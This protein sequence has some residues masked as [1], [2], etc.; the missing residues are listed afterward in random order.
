M[1]VGTLIYTLRFYFFCCL[2]KK[3]YIGVLASH[4]SAVNSFIHIASIWQQILMLLSLGFLSIAIELAEAFSIIYC[5]V[6]NRIR[7]TNCAKQC[8][9]G[10]HY[11]NNAMLIDWNEKLIEIVLLPIIYC[12]DRNDFNWFTFVL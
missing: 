10:V 4:K 2:L 7:S 1:H 8:P 5:Y 9:F 11:R 3:Y 12:I 6:N